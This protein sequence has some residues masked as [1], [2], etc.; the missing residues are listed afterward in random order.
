MWPFS[1][2]NSTVGNGSMLPIVECHHF[3]WFYSSITLSFNVLDVLDLCFR[4]SLIRTEIHSYDFIV[5][6]SDA[7]HFFV[8]PLCWAI[9]PLLQL[10]EQ[11]CY[12][13][14]FINLCYIIFKPWLPAL[15]P[16][17]TSARSTTEDISR[18]AGYFPHHCQVDLHVQNTKS[19]GS[20][21]NEVQQRPFISVALPPLCLLWRKMIPVC[22]QPCLL[23]LLRQRVKVVMYI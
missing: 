9:H 21:K 11:E 23:L 17:P 13:N 18:L 19:P 8:C 5:L 7:S 4:T 1:I 22:I 6:G 12:C 16:R 20:F 10:A 3:G 14:K 2:T 15:L